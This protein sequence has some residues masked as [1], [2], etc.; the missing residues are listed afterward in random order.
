MTKDCQNERLISYNKVSGQQ[1]NLL[2]VSYI[3]EDFALDDFQNKVWQQTAEINL[4]RYWSGNL[5]EPERHA[6]ARLLWSER[7]LIIRFE[8]N[9]REPL[10]TNS[11]LNVREKAIGLWERDVFE[12]FVA[13]EADKPEKYFEFEVAPTG[14]WLDAEI[15]ILPNC[16]RETNFEYHSGMKVATE[17]FENKVLATIKIEWRAFNKKP[18]IGEIWRGNLFRC[19]GSGKNRGYLAWQP[20][21]TRTPNFHVPEA[22]GKFEF[23][24]LIEKNSSE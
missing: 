7:E 15:E 8:G 18:Q 12:I 11:K 24:K 22:F 13:P 17:V 19:I 1:M 2:K 20:T 10:I 14:E 4:N 6:T 21:N 5:A 23:V 9:Q 16:R 3:S